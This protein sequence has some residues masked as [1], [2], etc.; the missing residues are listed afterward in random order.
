MTVTTVL[1]RVMDA[2]LIAWLIGEVLLQT[3]SYRAGGPVK[4]TEWRSFAAL[5]LAGVLGFWLAGLV[6]ALVPAAA[7]P[8]GALAAFAI[9]LPL[10]WAGIALRLWSIHRLGR[11]FRSV[12]HVQHDHRVVNSGPYRLLRH[13]AYTGALIG[14][15]GASVT[16]GNFAA[17][18]VVFLAVGAG[19]GYRIRV[20]ERVLRHELG[21]AYTDYA[22]RTARLIP[23]IW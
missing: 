5:V 21:R 4:T 19:I 18:A 2:T 7:V 20:E 15:L 8:G 6:A 10:A 11:F 22:A 3:R 16:G 23:G 17:T 14:V 12:V 13:P 9:G 1:G